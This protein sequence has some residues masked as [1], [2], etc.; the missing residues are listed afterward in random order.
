MQ[1]I[2]TPRL[3]L[4]RA[5]YLLL[6][7]GLGLSIWPSIIMGPHAPADSKTVVRAV[8]AA[9]GLFALVGLRYPL[10]M[11]PLLIFEAL[12]KTIW[13]VAFA[14]PLWRAGTMDA[15]TA[16]NAMECLVGAGLVLLVTPWGYVYQNYVRAP[17]DPWR[18]QVTR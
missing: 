18:R 9:V 3:L 8:L 6:A 7:A 10:R 4:L 12:W 17:G 11:L 1:T 16:K 13:L 2:G 15:T 14:L 5:M